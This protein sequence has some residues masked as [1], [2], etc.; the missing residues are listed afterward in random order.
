D[1]YW[2]ILQV[3]GTPIGTLAASGLTRG[4][5]PPGAPLAQTG[6]N[7]LI[8]GGT[9]AFLGARGQA[10]VIDLGSPRQ[11]SVVEDPAS[12]RPIGGAKRSYVLHVLPF[13]TPEILVNTNGPVVFRPKDGSLVTSAKP[14]Q[15]GEILTLY[16]S[17][18]GP[19]VPRMDPGQPFPDDPLQNVS[20]PVEI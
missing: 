11:A 19:T 18:L 20:S 14:A 2:E 7:L 17:G 5:P 15:A 6:D 8:T 10:G 13:S 4:S 12:R 16:A 9:G 3:D 1:M